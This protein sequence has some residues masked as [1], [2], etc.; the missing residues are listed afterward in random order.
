MNSPG[1]IHEQLTAQ[2]Y[3]LTAKFTFKEMLEPVREGFST[4][5]A[6]T[7]SFG[8]A[9]AILF[10]IITAL[11]TYY[12]VSKQL[13]FWDLLRN[14]CWGILLTFVLIPL[15]EW[16]HGLAFRHFGAKD[17]RYGVIWR[18]LM[19][20]AVSHLQVLGARQYFYIGLAPFV[21][22]TAAGLIVLP[23]CDPARQA[24]V[25]G[26]LC[27]HA[28]CCIGDFGLCAYFSKY[29]DRQPLTFDDAD[30]GTSYIYL[31]QHLE[32]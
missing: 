27:F 31:K 11:G 18:Y 12:M 2:G 1:S 6:F 32:S 24:I 3:E 14:F 8:W 19:F 9:I 29:I 28:L 30:T 10:T 21:L 15:H 4:R 17:V 13:F 22:I 5:N 23:F 25:M 20:Y 7:R 26:V 16:I